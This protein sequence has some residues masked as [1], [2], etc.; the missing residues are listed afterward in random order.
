MNINQLRYFVSAAENRS[1]TKAAAQYYISQ[2][3]VTQQIQA[4]EYTVGVALFDRSSRPISLTPAGKLFLADANSCT[5]F[6]SIKITGLFSSYG[7]L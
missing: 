4:L 2:T 3:A 6:S 1:F 7:L 5:G